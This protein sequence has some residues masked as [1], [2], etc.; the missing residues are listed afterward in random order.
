MHLAIYKADDELV[1]Y[2]HVAQWLD[3]LSDEEQVG[4]SNLPLPTK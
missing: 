2:G 4:S 1:E 3:Q